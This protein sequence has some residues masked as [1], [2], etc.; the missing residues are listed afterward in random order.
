[1]KTGPDIVRDGLVL[2]YDAANIKS[3][4]G[5]PTV[6]LW[7]GSLH[8]Y[9]NYGVPATL[10][11]TGEKYQGYNVYRLGMT[12]TDAYSSAL[13]SFRIDLWSHGVYGGG[14]VF[15][16]NTKYAA[17]IIWKP[18]NKLDVIVGG[19]ASNIGD[20]TSQPTENLQNGWFRY[21]QTRNGYVAVDKTDN[22]F[23]SFISPSLQL[24][25]TVYIDFCCP[26][27][28]EKDNATQYTP[29]S[30][31]NTVATGG[32][33]IDLSKK[34]NNG[35]IN[36]NLLYSS[37]N[38]GC[39]LFDAIDSNV[40]LQNSS[41]SSITSGTV[42]FWS[43]MIDTSNWLFLTGNTTS[44][45]LLATSG[46]GAFYHS[47]CG[48]PTVYV[49]GVLNNNPPTDLN[50]H[51]ITAINVNLS[52]WNTFIMSQYSGTNFKYNGYMNQILFYNRSL[53]QQ[54]I[55]QNYNAQKSRYL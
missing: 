54:E 42:S 20:W 10:V 52:T 46:A 35:T 47:N 13:P 39:L 33:L 45:Y 25:E 7:T 4:R 31:G 32:G 14:M 48:S 36:N 41:L 5:E 27:I 26:Q 19:T 40:T 51:H 28:E 9:N 30:R 16:A 18:V 2:Y 29:T 11:A 22:V 50:W 15:K 8:V 37:N 44:Y 55:S 21:T 1:M 43:K 12:V 38:S 3:F 17:S 49:D 24:N 23:H 34:F 53:S 6:N